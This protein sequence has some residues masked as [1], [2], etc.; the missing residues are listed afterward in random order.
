MDASYAEIFD[1]NLTS[2][3]SEVKIT[4]Y[5]DR[6]LGFEDLELSV[7]ENGIIDCNCPMPYKLLSYDRKKYNIEASFVDQ[8]NGN[9]IEIDIV[10]E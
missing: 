6:S 10:D 7:D 8:N 1:L 9:T 3:I 4:K 5:L 2:K